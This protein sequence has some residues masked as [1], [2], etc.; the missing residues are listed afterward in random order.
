ME[1]EAWFPRL[2]IGRR[3]GGF[4]TAG[5]GTWRE[6]KESGMGDGARGLSPTC[7]YWDMGNQ[8]VGVGWSN[9]DLVPRCDLVRESLLGH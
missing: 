3:R 5:T 8:P 2:W 7:I 4:Q 6:S 9:D 1:E